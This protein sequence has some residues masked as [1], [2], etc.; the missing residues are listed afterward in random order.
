MPGDDIQ[1]P[2]S[3]WAVAS[4]VSSSLIGPVILGILLD[5]Q[6]GWAPWGVIGGVL[7][8]LAGCMGML[9]RIQNRNSGPGGAAGGSPP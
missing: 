2:L 1:S 4:V 6:L 5:T 9:V 7:L 8:G 3:G